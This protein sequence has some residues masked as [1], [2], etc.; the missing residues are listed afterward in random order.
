MHVRNI[1]GANDNGTE[2][3]PAWGVPPNG[4]DAVTA[5]KQGFEY[6][7][8]NNGAGDYTQV[9][10]SKYECNNTASGFKRATLEYLPGQNHYTVNAGEILGSYLPQRAVTTPNIVN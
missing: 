3:M 8:S 10:A 5:S 9:S 4:F 7:C 1:L 2:G 6:Y